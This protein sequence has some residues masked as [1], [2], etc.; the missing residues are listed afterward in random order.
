MNHIIK[1]K[2]TILLLSI[3]TLISCRKKTDIILVGV[4]ECPG[5]CVNG[6][7]C[8]EDTGY[9]DCPPGYTGVL[10]QFQVDTCYMVNCLNGGVCVS[11]TCDCP[12]EWTGIDCTTPTTQDITY[13]PTPVFDICPEQIGGSNKNFNNAGPLVTISTKATVVE[14]KRIYVNI[15]FHLIQTSGASPTEGSVEVN[16][17]I[18][19][20]PEGKKIRT[21]SSSDFSDAAY[22]DNNDDPDEVFPSEGELVR[23][24]V[25][26]GDTPAQDLDNCN[27]GSKLDVYFNEMNIELIA[28]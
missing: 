5:T 20:A 9:C 15:V 1:F 16:K 19:Q 3:I 28:E 14:S 2:Y 4:D 7:A 25:V 11:G 17:L 23:K 13:T 18:Y 21:F 6:G 10:C 24:F 12:P 26:V 22:T 27:T 8:N